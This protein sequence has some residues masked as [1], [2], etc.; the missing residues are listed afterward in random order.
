MG[1]HGL[2]G[3][4]VEPL[5]K[6]LGATKGSFYW[7]FRDR[8]ELITAALERWEQE[9]TEA[10]IATLQPVADARARLRQL[11]TALFVTPRGANSPSALKADAEHK[12]VDI[13]IALTADP[14][15]PAVAEVIAR[16]TARRVSY[17]A[18]Q[19]RDVGIA[20][21]EAHRR[22]LLAYTAYLGSSTL[23]R[24]APG[25]MP[26]GRDAERWVESML[27]VLTQ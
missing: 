1:Q 2:S 25:T 10:V 12:A 20:A 19:L 4:A 14:E 13:S 9:G 26:H 8:E 16:V 22:A 6:S 7:H 18:D 17:I 15:H 11:L 24:S 27:S 5:A 21:D 23:A 3:I